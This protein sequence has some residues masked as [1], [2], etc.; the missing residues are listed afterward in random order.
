[1]PLS[2]V[3]L[4][5]SFFPSGCINKP[6]FQSFNHDCKLNCKFIPVGNNDITFKVIRQLH[7]LG[8]ALAY[9]LKPIVSNFLRLTLKKQKKGKGKREKGKK[10][11][12][13]KRKFILEDRFVFLIRFEISNSISKDS[14]S[15]SHLNRLEAGIHFLIE[16]N[17]FQDCIIYP[18]ADYMPFFEGLEA[19]LLKNIAA[20]DMTILGTGLYI[21]EP[22]GRVAA[23]IYFIIIFSIFQDRIIC[24]MGNRSLKYQI[25][26]E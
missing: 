1:M 7:L 22:R 15:H 24:Q 23:D 16:L 6:R 8:K 10:N 18:C 9:L 3:G 17:V 5:D 4:G 13:E 12:R 19:D 25:R 26:K 2:P 20:Q 11:K 21:L 14:A